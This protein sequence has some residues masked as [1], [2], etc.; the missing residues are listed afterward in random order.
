LPKTVVRH[1]IFTEPISFIK[2]N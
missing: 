2:P 1:V